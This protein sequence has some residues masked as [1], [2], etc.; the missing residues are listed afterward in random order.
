MQFILKAVLP[1]SSFFYKNIVSKYLLTTTLKNGQKNVL[2]KV[3][4]LKK[5]SY[6]YH[7]QCYMV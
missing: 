5:I 4:R 6:Y 2:K 7:C 1:K 3:F